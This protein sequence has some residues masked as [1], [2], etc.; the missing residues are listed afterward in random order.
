[1][2]QDFVFSCAIDA[3]GNWVHVDEVPRGERCGC[4]CPTCGESLGARQGD[5]NEHG[6]YHLSKKRGANLKICLKVN[7]YK[8]AENIIKKYKR[9][10]LPSYYGIFK[11]EEI[12][13]KDVRID[14]KYDRED[15]QPDVIATTEDGT[16]ILI[17][18][19]FEY[20]V[21]H[22]K[23]IDYKGL[24]CLEVDLSNQTGETIEKFLM[25]SSEGRKWMNNEHYFAHIEEK[26]QRNNKPIRLV[27]ENECN[28]CELKDECCAV[29]KNGTKFIIENSGKRYRL[30]K[31]EIYDKVIEDKQKHIE[32]EKRKRKEAIITQQIEKKGW[33]RYAER[34]VVNCYNCDKIWEIAKNG[35]VK[36]GVCKN[37]SKQRPPN[38]ARQ[39]PY[40]RPKQR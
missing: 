6:F 33:E 23:A 2:E 10:K 17:E 24:N 14:D 4:I 5:V 30:C 39:C 36:C 3:A 13:F 40:F 16:E 8:Y 22:K 34:E 18:F 21:Q 28:G 15:K 12:I 35:H 37:A 25:D 19:I 20:K 11:E 31:V 32:E 7:M 27:C 9:I 26:Y 29:E 1:M 38:Y